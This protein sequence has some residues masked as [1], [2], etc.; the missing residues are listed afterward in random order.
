MIL[1]SLRFL[2]L[3]S[4][5]AIARQAVA[6]PLVACLI[7]SA[8]GGGSGS[9]TA[10]NATPA[11]SA[12][13][14]APLDA[15]AIGKLIFRDTSL[16]ASGR[17]SCASCHNPDNAHAPSNDLAAQSG[18]PDLTI[19][20]GRA[21]PSLRYL[22][23]T[24]RF[25][26]AADGTPSG[27]F[28]RDGRAQMLAEQAQRPLLAPHEM[29]NAS[30][31]AV[32]AR[33]QAAPYAEQ[34]RALYGAAIFD[35]PAA[36]FERV[37][38]ALQ[39]YQKNDSAFFPFDSKYDRFIAGQATL[40]D[41]ELRGLALF[42]NSTKGN[43]AACHPSA[44]A[45]DG[46]RPLFTDFSFDNLGVPRN[47]LLLANRDPA[48]YDLGLCGPDRSDLAQRTDLCGAFK[49]PTLRNVATRKVFFH[50][51]R[52]TSLRD[53]VSFYVRRDTNPEEWYPVAADGTVLKF[54]DL[55]AQFRRNVNVAEVPYNRSP[56]QAPALSNAEIDDVVQFLGTLTDG[57]RAP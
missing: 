25:A 36:A 31:A 8:C 42:N 55:P 24:P 43:C 37:L 28:N 49:V 44:K 1:R 18:G 29:A 3:I 48:Y 57:Y 47:P 11:T 14:S 38:L 2:A 35:D 39:Q 50:N 16:S 20:G 34:F 12:Q 5:K 4:A 30:P 41:A 27:G 9:T 45:A 17:L 53:A 51:G 23:L 40:S 46:S 10:T 19:Q 56:G 15:V 21:A 33:L 54:D 6:F 22:N 13:P 52:F 7:L 26:I 32:V